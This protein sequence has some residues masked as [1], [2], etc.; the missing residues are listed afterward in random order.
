MTL[1]SCSWQVDTMRHTMWH[2]WDSGAVSNTLE[3]LPAV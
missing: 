2:L 1:L 3:A